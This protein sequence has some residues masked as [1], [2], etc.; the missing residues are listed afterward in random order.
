M[1]PWFQVPTPGS[2]T[3]NSLQKEEMPHV[4][5][6]DNCVIARFNNN[7]NNNVYSN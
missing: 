5:Q 2:G 6:R 4:A 7:N 3:E 1:A